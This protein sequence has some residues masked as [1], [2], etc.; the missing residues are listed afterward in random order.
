LGELPPGVAEAGETA[1]LPWNVDAPTPPGRTAHCHHVV[2]PHLPCCAQRGPLCCNGVPGLPKVSNAGARSAS[3]L[4]TPCRLAQCERPARLPH[5]PRRHGWQH[6]G[7]S[8]RRRQRDPAVWF[9]R[10][11]DKRQAPVWPCC[12]GTWRQSLLEGTDA[13]FYLQCGTRLPHTNQHLAAGTHICCRPLAL[14]V[15]TP[16]PF[17]TVYISVTPDQR[18]DGCYERKSQPLHSHAAPHRYGFTSRQSCR[19]QAGY[20]P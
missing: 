8:W 11:P 13:T 16:T 1:G 5:R 7:V 2:Y 15:M 18:M 19:L 4:S 10:I 20:V 6:I 9:S 12:P 17:A 3:A 14:P